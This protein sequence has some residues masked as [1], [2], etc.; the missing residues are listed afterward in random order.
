MH[1]QFDSLFLYQSFIFHFLRCLIFNEY[2]LDDSFG[3]SDHNSI[4][5]EK[6]LD[7]NK[8]ESQPVK[9]NMTQHES[10]MTRRQFGQE[11]LSISQISWDMCH[12][13]WLQSLRQPHK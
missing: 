3:N 12:D 11:S 2:L 7:R 13:L 6:Q 8:A 1:H 4:T 10:Q 5:P 9:L